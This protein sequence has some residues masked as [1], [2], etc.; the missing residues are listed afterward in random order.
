[1][2]ITVRFPGLYI[3]L[4]NT[5]II[6]IGGAHEFRSP[7]KHVALFVFGDSRFDPGNNNY[8]NTA[9]EYQANFW[10]YGETFFG[11]P[12][13][14]FSDGRLIPDFICEYAK[15]PL[16]PP[17]LKP[18]VH[19]YE[20]GVNF[21]SGGA[22][23]LIETHQGF[24]VDLQTQL[25]YFKN[26]VKQLRSKL[27]DQEAKEL[28]S[29]AVYFFSV[30]GNDYLS[31]F[32]SDSSFF[33]KYSKKEYVGIVLGNLTQVI[34]G[35][36]KIGGRKFGFLNMT[37]LGCLPAVKI[38]Q[39]GNT[40]S[41]VEEL[42]SLAKLHNRELPKVL[43]LIQRQ[44]KGFIYS[45]HDFYTSFGEILENPLKYG[46]K[47]VNVACCGTGPSRGVFSCG[48][49]RE[50]KEFELCNNASDF[51]FFDSLHPTEKAY[52]QVAE[53][54]WSGESDIGH[55]EPFN[56]KALFELEKSRVDF[57]IKKTTSNQRANAYMKLRSIF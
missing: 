43:Q 25:S 45:E 53:L 4:I 17:Y 28:I 19:N 3:M 46:F 18:G 16:I 57:G 37:P 14:R 39:P 26:V 41:C 7:E 23:A 54:I 20:Y 21:A 50:V 30:G 12:T 9:T 11:F 33:D 22:G 48:G 8:I 24:V 49:N 10:P 51:L 47:E 52:K 6:G 42:N 44:L 56:L 1:M 55:T 15:L 40:G 36:Y 38:V 35:I 31:P 32:T 2:A 34:E 13:G 27:G 29:S 5:V